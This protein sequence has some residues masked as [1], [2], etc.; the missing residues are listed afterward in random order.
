RDTQV[1]EGLTVTARPQG[2][3]LAV[4]DAFR[5]ASG[6]YA[7]QGLPG[8]RA[9]EYPAQDTDPVGSPPVTRRFIVEVTDQERRFLPMVLSVE[10]PYRGVFPTGTHSSPLGHQ[11]PGVYLFSSPTRPAMP[12]LAV[13]RAQL[14]DADTRQ[15]AAH[16]L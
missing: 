10:L 9:V 11:L 6:V 12:S 14:V 4:T 3:R 1:S 8:M 15:P 5:T 13:V 16:A 2:T 7:F